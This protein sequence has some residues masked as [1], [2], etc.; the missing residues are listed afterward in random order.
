MP[1]PSKKHL[2]HMVLTSLVHLLRKELLMLLLHLSGELV[3]CI[4]G[5]MA[6]Y[7]A[8]QFKSTWPVASV[9]LS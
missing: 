8:R 6:S 7:L 5:G 9:S 1:R 2:F 4:C 3:I